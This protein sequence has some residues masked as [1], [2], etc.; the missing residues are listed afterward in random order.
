MITV[1]V[2]SDDRLHRQRWDFGIQAEWGCENPALV[3]TGYSIE[4]RKSVLGKFAAAKA[5]D[6]WSNTDERSY[7]SGIKR[8]QSIPADVMK[9]ALSK[10][11]FQFFIASRRGP[12]LSEDGSPK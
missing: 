9:E 3:L 5:E 12:E 2:T 10:V 6:R 8:P 4:R 11:T 1:F 7:Y